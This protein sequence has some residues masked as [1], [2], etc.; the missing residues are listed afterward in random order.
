MAFIGIA[1]GV[2]WVEQVTIVG[3]VAIKQIQG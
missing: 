2:Q 3:L 1:T